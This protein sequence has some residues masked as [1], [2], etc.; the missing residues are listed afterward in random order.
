MTDHHL[1]A[2]NL[3]RAVSTCSSTHSVGPLAAWRDLE[4]MILDGAL[5]RDQ[6]TIIGR[7]ATAMARQRILSRT[8]DYEYTNDRNTISVIARLL[9]TSAPH[10][11]VVGRGNSAQFDELSL[12]ALAGMHVAAAGMVTLTG[13]MR[14]VMR[15]AIEGARHVGGYTKVITPDVVDYEDGSCGHQL[16]DVVLRTGLPPH[17]RNQLV[18]YDA[19]AMIIV[20]GSHG[21]MQECAFA[22]DRGIPVIRLGA[23][24]WTLPGII[25]SH[26]SLLADT[27]ANLK[28]WSDQR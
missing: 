23:T 6:L 9:G 10:V 5:T 11:A 26:D 17:A 28:L 18:A 8:G 4:T 27:L 3:R 15:K 14:G 25:E 16:A 2:D 1:L 21:T 24:G 7:D 13:G 20:G 19:D 22:L 12:A